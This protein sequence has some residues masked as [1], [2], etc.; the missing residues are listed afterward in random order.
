MNYYNF[1]II[2][3]KFNKFDIVWKP[4]PIG[5][6][7]KNLKLKKGRLK[8]EKYFIFI[9]FILFIY[10]YYYDFFFVFFFFFFYKLNNKALFLTNV[11]I[12]IDE[13]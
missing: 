3:K 4:Q 6:K 8:V 11:N 12:R 1:L 13:R 9:Y 10:L 7:I 5:R 2:Q